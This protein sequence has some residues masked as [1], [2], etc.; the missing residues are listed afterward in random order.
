MLGR[1]QCDDL[2]EEHSR[3]REPLMP[4]PQWEQARDQQT[5]LGV[6]V[7]MGTS[8]GL[9]CRPPRLGVCVWPHLQ[10]RPGGSW[11]DWETRE[12]AGGLDGVS[13]G[14]RPGRGLGAWRA[15][16]GVGDPGEGWEPGGCEQG[17]RPGRGLGAWRV[18]VGW[19]TRDRAGS[20]EGV[21]GVRDTGEGWLQ[22][23]GQGGG[24]HGPGNG[25]GHQWGIPATSA[26]DRSWRCVFDYCCFLPLLS[27][28]P[29]LPLFGGLFTAHLGVSYLSYC[30]LDSVN[31]LFPSNSCVGLFPSNMFLVLPL[32]ACLDLLWPSVVLQKMCLS[33]LPNTDT[34]PLS[35]FPVTCFPDFWFNSTVV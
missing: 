26:A 28:F 7:A 11:G 6:D 8:G 30:S 23:S 13:G 21:S 27:S 3:L 22:C 10:L 25:S 19:E 35:D 34:V 29:L 31:L 32:L 14:E 12:R 9:S 1:Q 18:W 5:W 2:E 16:V 4:S 33:S 24:G 15:W 17:E 20:L